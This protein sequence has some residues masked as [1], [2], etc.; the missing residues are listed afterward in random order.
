MLS[1]TYVSTIRRNRFGLAICKRLIEAQ[2]SRIYL[3]SVLGQGSEFVFELEFN[4]V[5][6]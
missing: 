5:Y 3:S 6:E 2:N 1:V 4:Q